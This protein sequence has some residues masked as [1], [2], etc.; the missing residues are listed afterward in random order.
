MF[1]IIA[2]FLVGVYVGQEYNQIPNIKEKT[3]ELYK[4]ISKKN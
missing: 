3:K 1:K 2:A 4:E